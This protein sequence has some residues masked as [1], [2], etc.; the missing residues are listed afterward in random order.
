MTIQMPGDKVAEIP[1]IIPGGAAFSWPTLR[2]DF[3]RLNAYLS[4]C[5]RRGVRYGLGAKADAGGRHLAAFPPQY[6]AIDCSGFVRAALAYAAGVVMVDG[7]VC[8]HDWIDDHHFKISTY[9][10]LLLKDGALRIA[11]IAPSRFERIGHVYLVRNGRTLESYGGHGPGSRSPLVHVLHAFT[12]NVFVL[13]APE[14]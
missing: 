2:V 11:F 12:T 9:S 8:Q 10:A 4:A 7:S 3:V 14:A 13:T 5:I 1:G 6:R